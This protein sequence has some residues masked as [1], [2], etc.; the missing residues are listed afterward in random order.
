MGWQG[1]FTLGVVAVALAAMVRGVAAPDLV[2]M[3]ALFS[4]A[5]TG[6][7]TVSETFSGFANPVVPTIGALFVVSAALRETG[8]LEVALGRVLGRTSSVRRALLRMCAPVAASSAFLNNAPIVAMMTPGVIDWSRRKAIS[9]SRM[10]IPLSYAAILGSTT[11]LIGTSVNLT[12]A[13]L[14]E[15][16]G[17][18]SMS[19]FEL[20]P[21]GLPIAL[22]GV[23]YLVL[24]GPGLLPSR[25]DPAEVLGERRREYTASMRVRPDSA[26]VGRSV[27]EAELRNLPGL[28]LVEIS[29]GGR[30]VTPVGPE[31]IIQ[32]EDRLVFAG[33]VAR[34]VDLQRIRG[35]VPV[36]EHEEVPHSPAD[37]RLVE[38]V[39]SASSPLVDQS[40]RESNFR[41]VYD[42]AVIA[43]HR[44]GERVAG[45]IGEIVLRPGD[46][47]LLQTAQGFMRA[48][49][50]SPDFYL[51]SEVEG[52][53]RVRHERAGVAV[54]VLAAMVLS[55]VLGVL[56][57][58][59]AV[60]LA[61]GAMVA[62]RCLNGPRARRSVDWSILVVIG[63]GLGIALAMQKTGAARAVASVLVGSAG[64]LG[65][66]AALGVIYLVTLAMAES[67]HHN[68]AVAIMF[69][70]AA[71]TAQQL[72][73]EPRGFVMAIALGS[74]CAFASPVAY[75]THLIVY[76]PGGYR[77][78][79]FLKMGLPLDLLCAAVA[80]AVIPFVWPF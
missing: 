38:A 4:L 35:L 34:I 79:D 53:E 52:A 76:G 5:T 60:F 8:A 39:I 18:R 47:L 21:V 33:V 59:V 78:T 29:R 22:A 44:N 67:L 10:L 14:I 28:F 70:I 62:L 25:R 12:V 50:N 58:P 24:V 63:A 66:L 20:L 36:T 51:V 6:I 11:T 19:F 80:L 45:K 23:A 43:V 68:A 61:A 57:L 30:A 31:E 37:P 74:C 71:A 1:W 2:M 7:L 56:P 27:G 72:G 55:N 42:A 16:A 64:Q 54:L 32:A 26:L 41:T 40:I 17:M 77:F 49:R 13:G 73:V 9:P 65:P 75:Q 3:A 69:P 48:H 46:T 15:G